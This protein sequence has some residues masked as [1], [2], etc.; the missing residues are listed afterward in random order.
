MIVHK[1]AQEIQGVQNKSALILFFEFTF[2]TE[3]SEILCRFS[4]VGPLKNM[5]NVHLVQIARLNPQ[6]IL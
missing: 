1:L 5:Y 4:V 6:N 3:F 2:T